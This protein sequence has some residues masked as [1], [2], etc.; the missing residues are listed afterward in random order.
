MSFKSIVENEKVNESP[1]GQRGRTSYSDAQAFIKD[2]QKLVGEFK[3][4][5][6]KMGG[7]AVASHILTV[8]NIKSG[9]IDESKETPESY[10]RDVGFKIKEVVPN[11]KG[12]EIELYKQDQVESAFEELKSAGFMTKYTL[13]ATNRGIGVE[14]L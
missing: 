7:K 9:S 6:T 1:V 2:N 14:E 8:M 10:L 5:V 12:Y 3:K 11:K 13:Y 4:I